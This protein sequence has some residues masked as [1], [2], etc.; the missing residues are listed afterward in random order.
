MFHNKGRRRVWAQDLWPQNYTSSRL[1]CISPLNMKYALPYFFQS[2]PWQSHHWWGQVSRHGSQ[3]YT[4]E[5]NA[6]SNLFL[7][8]VGSCQGNT[9]MHSRHRHRTYTTAPQS[10]QSAFTFAFSW[11]LTIVLWTSYSILQ[12][13]RLQARMRTSP[14]AHRWGVEAG[15]GWNLGL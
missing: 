10:L 2:Q 11:I 9:V 5:G 4:W 7:S 13:G 1:S 6:F 8:P 14:R 15:I 12:S 3:S